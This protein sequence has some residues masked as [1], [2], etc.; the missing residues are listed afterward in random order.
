MKDNGNKNLLVL[1]A[2]TPHAAILQFSKYAKQENQFAHVRMMDMTCWGNSAPITT[3][4][5]QTIADL[6][7]LPPTT[8]KIKPLETMNVPMTHTIIVNPFQEAALMT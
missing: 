1:I 3:G 2:K 8:L 7:V 6:G 5:T 4:T